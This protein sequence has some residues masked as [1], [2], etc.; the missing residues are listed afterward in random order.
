MFEVHKLNAEGIDKAE[1]LRVVFKDAL[2]SVEDVCGHNGY[3]ITPPAILRDLS[4]IA[5]LQR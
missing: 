3:A 2:D 1:E 5:T 4:T